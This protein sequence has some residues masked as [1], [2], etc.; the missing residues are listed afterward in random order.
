M[1]TTKWMLP[2]LSIGLMCSAAA[3]PKAPA[4]KAAPAAKTAPAAKE[5]SAN[6]WEAIPAVVAVVDGKNITREDVK[7]FLISQM[8]DGKIPPM[9]NAELL[10]QM[11]PGIV[12]GMVEQQLMEKAMG[13]S[14]IKVTPQ[15]IETEL[16]KELNSMPKEQRAMLEQQFTMQNTTIEKRIQEMAS[17]PQIQKQFAMRQFLETKVLANVKK[18][19]EAEAKA[20]YDK[21]INQFK[22][23]EMLQVSHILF[24]PDEKAKDKAAA[25]KAALDK[26]IAAYKKLQKT[27]AQF[28]EIAKAESACP[29]KAQ[30]GK[31]QPFPKGKGMMVKEFEDAAAAI[32]TK[33]K[34]VGP[35][36]TQFG[37]HLIRLDEVIPATTETFAKAK[38]SIEAF[39]N[40]QAQQKAIQD[41]M[42]ALLKANKVTFKVD[43]PKAM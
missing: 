5:V 33:G 15:M 39:L 20:F 24:V 6:M 17:N 7:A 2:I 38:A 26:A 25:D 43:M 3:A 28:E 21:N 37:Y 27:P 42:A 1:K 34:I 32:G 19:S 13:K 22:R 8:P 11:A 14:G 35:V 23:D 41:Y 4:A 30:G 40:G 12:R 9:F 16:K 10:K 18:V 36:K 29:S 31:L